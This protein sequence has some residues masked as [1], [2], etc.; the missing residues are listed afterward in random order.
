MKQTLTI[1]LACILILGSGFGIFYV[2]YKYGQREAENR[3]ANEFV[4]QN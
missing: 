4:N 3:I 1:I 2:G